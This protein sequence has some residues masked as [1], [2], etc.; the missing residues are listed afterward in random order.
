MKSN[1]FLNFIF[2]NSPH[3]VR[4]NVV[5]LLGRIVF[6]V[7]LAYHGLIKVATFSDLSNA[8]PNPFGLGAAASLSLVIFAEVFCS[9]LVLIGLVTR[10][11]VMPIVFA[12]LVAYL[13]VHGGYIVDGGELPFIYAIIF[14]LIGVTGAGKY[15]I[16][17]KIHKKFKHKA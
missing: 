2:P 3:R 10:L 12:M 8:F 4:V 7:L 17:Y 16:D 13:F 6:S 15:S 11:A 1:G 5:L 9:L 14:A